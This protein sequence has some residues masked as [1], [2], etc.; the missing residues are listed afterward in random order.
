[1]G[2]TMKRTIWGALAA[3]AVVALLAGCSTQTAK[4][5]PQEDP[6]SMPMIIEVDIVYNMTLTADTPA[7]SPSAAAIC[8]AANE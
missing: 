7:V 4:V 6:Q 2:A 1:M 8:L 5:A 3:A